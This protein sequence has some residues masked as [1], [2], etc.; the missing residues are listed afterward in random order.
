MQ[1]LPT[2]KT[3]ILTRQKHKTRRHLARLPRPAHR[4]RAELIHRITFHRAWDQWRPHGAW[5]YRIHAD[6]ERNL[7]V[8]EAA[9]ESDIGAFGGGV[10]EEGGAA[11]VG[12]YGGVVDDGVAGFHM[13]EGVLGHVKVGVDVCVEGFDPLVSGRWGC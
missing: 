5:T 1:A 3:A 7:L 11:D 4:R 8:A 13:F 9:G 12:V 10:V 2:H 6:A